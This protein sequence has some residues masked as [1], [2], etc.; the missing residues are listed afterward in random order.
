MGTIPQLSVESFI[1]NLKIL[2]VQTFS[3]KNIKIKVWFSDKHFYFIL[4][5]T[6]YPTVE[7]EE[8]IGGV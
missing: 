7:G 6:T 8:V 3:K 2:S 1:I 4:K 5:V